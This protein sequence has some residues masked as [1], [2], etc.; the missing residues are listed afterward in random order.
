MSIND[1][2]ELL[3]VSAAMLLLFFV[4]PLMARRLGD[5]PVRPWYRDAVPA[6]IRASVFFEITALIL[7]GWRL[8]F[9]GLMLFLVLCWVLVTIAFAS[10]SRWVWD[11][12]QWRFGYLRALEW[13]EQAAI[14]EARRQ[15]ELRVEWSERG[16]IAASL[17]VLAFVG[18]VWFALDHSRF[19]GS[20]TYQRALSLQMLVNGAHW[21]ANG[22]VALLAPVSQFSGAGGGAVIRFSGPIFGTLLAVAGAYCGWVYSR[23]FEA[24][25]VAFCVL[26]LYPVFPGFDSPGEV[27]GA[28]IACVFWIL[29][30]AMARSS[31]AYALAS[32][33]VA[34]LV[35]PRLTAVMLGTLIAVLIALVL[36]ALDRRLPRPVVIPSRMAAAAVFVMLVV[37]SIGRAEPEGPFQYESVARVTARIAR[38]FPRNRW[39]LVSPAQE[40]ASMYGR[41]WHVELSEF[42]RTYT[43][44]EVGNP[45]FRF[46]Y[47][48]ND[49]FI[50]VEKEPLPQ[51]AQGAAMAQDE[52]S[53]EYFT[54]IGRTWLEFQAAEIAA[55]YASTHAAQVYYEDGQILVYHVRPGG[56]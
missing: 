2:F 7:G 50:V 56:R 52:Y 42:V 16:V 46:P 21:A 12:E 35:Y 39:M 3:R 13:L 53:Y 32:A 28:E 31:W 23:R 9:A 40:V 22:S 41:G 48:V 54:Q 38:E 51:R 8:C 20:Q 17:L 25:V 24:S 44:Q 4:L 14:P 45:S 11:P 29:A 55:A 15:L 6:F 34:Y 5:S 30:V 18:Q 26:A 1:I 33:G 37:Q 19:L 47:S 27:A 49:L 43:P 10:R 36:D